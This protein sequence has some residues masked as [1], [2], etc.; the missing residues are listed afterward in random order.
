MISG[1]E[2]FAPSVAATAFV[3]RS[4]EVIGNV[5][6]EEKVSVW[7]CAVLRGDVEEIVIGEETNVQDCAVIHTNH[8]YPVIVGKRVTVG[9][10]ATLHG[11]RI[12][13]DCLVGIGAIVLD[14]AVL[15]DR[16]LVAAGSLVPPS[17]KVPSG[18]LVMGTPAKV[19]RKLKDG[20]IDSII[21][22]GK[23][24]AGLIAEYKDKKDGII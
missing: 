9:H 13:N 1:F 7:P 11:C 16:V 14:G 6:L 5:K 18:S 21:S 4:A 10:G 2:G 24:Y 23:E 8:G 15:E 12:G 20:E 3:H 22:N 19:V 17:M